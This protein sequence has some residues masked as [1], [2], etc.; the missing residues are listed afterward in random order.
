MYKPSAFGQ[1]RRAVRYP[2]T[3]MTRCGNS[4]REALTAARAHPSA[5]YQTPSM[6]PRNMDHARLSK[7]DF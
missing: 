1:V 7:V 2:A 5:D 3:I 6:F 4:C